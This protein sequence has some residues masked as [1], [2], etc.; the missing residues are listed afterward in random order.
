MAYR[1][2]VKFYRDG[3]E[4][5]C[6]KECGLF[7]SR[8]KARKIIA[9]NAQEF[10]DMEALVEEPDSFEVIDLLERPERKRRLGMKISA[11]K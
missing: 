8:E 7:M 5:G 1:F 2:L 10:I 3:E 6:T 11:G 9:A 4:V